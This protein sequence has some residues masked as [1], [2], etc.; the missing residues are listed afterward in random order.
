MRRPNTNRF[1]LTLFV[2][3]CLL[4][5]L[6]ELS[7]PVPIVCAE[8]DSSY[9]KYTT[10]SHRVGEIDYKLGLE[11]R[12]QNRWKSTWYWIDG[13]RH[14]NADCKAALDEILPEWV[15]RLCLST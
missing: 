2:T 7:I 8:A 11:V 13:A 9:K 6:I 1:Q 14:D 12:E 3:V 15:V 10:M 4:Y 5:L